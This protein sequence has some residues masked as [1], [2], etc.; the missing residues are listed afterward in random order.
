[1][2]TGLRGAALFFAFYLLCGIVAGVGFAAMDPHDV[3]VGASGAI[4][5]LIGGAVRLIDGHGRAA[6]L[7]S[8]TVIGFSIVWGGRQLRAGQQRGDREYRSRS[9]VRP[10]PS[11]SA[12]TSYRSHSPG[13]GS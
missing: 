12:D 1:M 3:A 2:G 11:Q 6:P 10:Q 8:R 4:S 9:I 7:L 5:G 13:L